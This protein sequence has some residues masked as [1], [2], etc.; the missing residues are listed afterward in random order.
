METQQNATLALGAYAYLDALTI[1]E[2]CW[3]FLRRNADYRRDYSE[4][5]ASGK[6]DDAEEVAERWRLSFPGRSHLTFAKGDAFLAT[7]GGCG[8]SGS[9][10]CAG[11]SCRRGRRVASARPAEKSPSGQGRGIPPTYDCRRA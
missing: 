10:T 8:H 3:E 9:C 7:G 4:A 1:P 2:F 11:Y 5:M 6:P